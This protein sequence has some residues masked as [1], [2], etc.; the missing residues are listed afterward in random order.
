MDQSKTKAVKLPSLNIPTFDGEPTNWKSYWQQFEATIH[1]SKKLD[2][3]LRM[4]YLLKSLVTKRA[5]DAIEGIDAVGEAYP[6]AIA[7]LKA[8]FDQ[9]QVIHRAHVRALLN[10]KPSKDSSSAELRQLHD[11]FQHH[12]RSMK[13]LGQLDFERFITALGESKLDP[14]TMVEWQKFTQK[15]KEVPDYHQLLEFLDLRSTATELTTH[16]SDR[17]KPQA[18][19][20]KF[21]TNPSGSVPR[22]VSVYA[23][24]AQTRCPAC[25]SSRNGL[26]Y[27]RNFKEKTLTDK[28]DFVLAQGLCFNCLKPKHIGK[29]CPSPNSCLKCNKRCIFGVCM[30]KWLNDSPLWS[31]LLAKEQEMKVSL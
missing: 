24:S 11:T 22:P 25:S 26:A 7:A 10:V 1:K 14:V 13:A 17:K 19:Y 3:Q 30:R 16:Y 9:P 2:D 18:S 15:E 21:K 29:H 20:S 8:R 4:Q 23:T 12:L 27:C 5:K 31:T 28:R 6:E